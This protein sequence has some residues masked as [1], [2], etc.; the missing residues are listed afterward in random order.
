MARARRVYLID[1]SAQLHRAYF[2][3]KGLATTRGLPTNA[4]Y[5]FTTML[6]KLYQDEDPEWVG[7]SFDLPGAT[8]RH[9][10]YAEY[11]AT[12]R[13]MD[14]DLA[15]QLP[16]VE[17]VCRV[18]GLPRQDV[19]GFEADDVIATLARQAVEAGLKVV[20]VSGDKDLLQL[21]T[22]DVLVISPGREG[23]PS[24]F[25][26]RKTVEEKWGVPPERV[27]DVL[28]L[29]GDSVDN[30]PGVPGIGEK[31]ARD[32]V[33][34]FGPLEEVLANV[35]QIKRNAYREGLLGHR[36]D[37]LL[38]KQLVRLRTD[39]PV[40][41]DLEALRRRPP[42][43]AAAHAL[44][45]ELEFV[46]LAKEYAPEAG[47][48]RTQ[49]GVLTEPDAVREA[50]DQ[51]RKAGK[52]A[53]CFVRDAREP[54]RAQPLGV[55][56]AWR[57]GHAVYVPLSH[58]PLEVPEATPSAELFELLRPLFEDPLVQKLSARGK[59]DR[60]LLCEQGLGC[61]SLAFDALVASYLLNPGRRQ[62]SLEDLAVE[63][64]GERPTPA[65]PVV[66]GAGEV[67]LGAAAAAAAQDADIALRLEEPLR[68]RL[69]EEELSEIYERM[70]LPLIEVLA[71][72][73][74]AGVKVNLP[75]LADMSR[76]ME[77]HVAG[78]TARIHELAGGPF[79]INSPIQLRDI[80]FDRLGMK[81]AKKTAKTRAASTAEE[82]LEELARHHELPRKI[83]E[84][85]SVQKLKSTYVDALPQLVNPRTGR[86][87]ASFNQTVAATGRLSV[88]DPNLQNIP[89][90]TADGRKIR[91]AFVAERGHLLLSAD[92]SQIELRVLAHLSKDPTLIDTFRRGEDVHDRTGREIFGPL[93]AVEP[94]EQRR[95][96]KMVNYALLYGKT[97]F[98]LAKDIGVTQKEADQFIQAYF[99]RYPAVRTFIDETIA[100][101]RATG[102]VRTLLGRL[103]R[104]PDLSAKNFQVRMEAERQAMNTPVQGSAAD[105]IKKAMI[106]LHRELRR[107]RMRSRLILQIHDE[108]LL[109][110]PEDEAEAAR[111]MVR[112]IMEG[113]LELD[114]PLVADARL[115][116]SWAEVH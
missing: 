111:A 99:A 1:G 2:A 107:R 34:E 108:L 27:V 35:D 10:Q 113:A 56:L 89:I 68:R 66:E 70:E 60:I 78:L 82:V 109:E 54:M 44:F 112:E 47:A 17:R 77:G 87:H 88:A 73:E 53:V 110:V 20:V 114:V 7:I 5:G 85:R 14:D 64:L 59:H 26:D 23:A 98:T 16:F 96:S 52:V 100:R 55:A 41:L 50:V 103:R 45:T 3:I 90:R 63:F 19:P 39:V 13:R 69:Q 94:D 92:Y 79:N 72:M 93:S 49:Y 80:L 76:D 6:R 32:L 84:Y 101:A 74:R 33:R 25:Y 67:T 46:A 104:L 65:S 61:E 43:R 102:M 15:V 11:K 31:G 38:S 75:F 81:S 62:Y 29:V 83:L 57:R 86:I 8:F 48:S 22:D 106:D 116:S 12:R 51:A 18:F 21:V 42:D 95:V 30:V 58:S 36:E 24:T 71:D 115:G 4:V 28:A 37:A 40:T 9:Q 97:A 105:L 91:E